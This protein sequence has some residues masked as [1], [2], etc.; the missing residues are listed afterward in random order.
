[1]LLSLSIDP[2]S[3]NNLI[4]SVYVYEVILQD[5]I[6]LRKSGID[7]GQCLELFMKKES[8]TSIFMI[9]SKTKLEKI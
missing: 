3:L 2:S 1:M 6:P 5:D 9:S 8:E 7:F 4:M